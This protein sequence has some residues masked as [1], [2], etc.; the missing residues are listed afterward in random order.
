MLDF[1]NTGHS[2]TH[3]TLRK[4]LSLGKPIWEM[5]LPVTVSPRPGVLDMA[6]PMSKYPFTQKSLT[7]SE[8]GFHQ[9]GLGE[10][11]I[12]SSS[13]LGTEL[14]V[15]LLHHSCFCPEP[16]THCSGSKHNKLI[17]SPK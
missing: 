11:I 12:Q 9:N 4:A 13:M 3:K 10:V 8:R 15:R 16:L 5:A 7:H 6:G 17:G 14:L 2:F 1:A